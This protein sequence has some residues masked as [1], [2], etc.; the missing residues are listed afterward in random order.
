MASI[1]CAKSS[2]IFACEHM[3]L[4]LSSREVSHPIFSISKKKLISLAGQWHIG[5]LSPTESYL[6]Y[7]ALLNSTEL[8]IWRV[9]A[10][11]TAKTASIVANNMEALIHI[12]GKVD[13]IQHPSFVLPHFAI[14]SDTCNLENS[15]HWIQAWIANYNEWYDGLKSASEREEYKSRLESRETSLSRLIKTADTSVEDLSIVLASWAE[16]AGNFPEFLTSH[17]ITRRPIPINEYWKQI[18]RAC[19]N[20]DAI[21]RFPSGDISELIHHCEDNIIHGNIQSHSLMKLLR[22]GQKRHADYLGFSD[23]DLGGKQ[24]TSF[25]ILDSESSSEDAN[26]IAAIN[27]APEL[28]PLA[29]NYPNKFSYLKAKANWDMARRYKENGEKL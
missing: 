8:I 7:L 9:P 20:D 22:N 13:V 16:V 10:Q 18:I 11:Y 5:K 6:L 28:E 12:I 1:V 29:K 27:A 14:S 3:P 15:Y 23:I 17:P 19:A 25:T 2:V 21:W 24:A 26:K 4:S